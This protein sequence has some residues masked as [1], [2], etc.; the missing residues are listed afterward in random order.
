MKNLVKKL[1]IFSCSLC[2]SFLLFVPF[3]TVNADQTYIIAS[4]GIYMYNTGNSNMY[5]KIVNNTS[6]VRVVA[7]TNETPVTSNTRLKFFWVSENSFQIGYKEGSMPSSWNNAIQSAATNF[8]YYFSFRT[9][10]NYLST[11]VPIIYINDPNIQWSD[12][13]QL[14]VYAVYYTFGE[15]ASEPEPVLSF[16]NLADVS[17][18]SNIAG[19]G[20]ETINN[21]DV[22]RWNNVIDNHNNLVPDDAL[23]DIRA[24]PGE[25]QASDK[26]SLLTKIYTDLILDYTNFATLANVPFSDGTKSFRWGDVVNRFSPLYTFG[27]FTSMIQGSDYWYKQGWIYEVRLRIPSE[28][29]TS[30]WIGIRNLTSSGVVNSNNAIDNNGLDS[31]LIQTINNINT[32]NTT[33]NNEFVTNN[34]YYNSYPVPENSS[35]L[36]DLTNPLKAI[37]EAILNLPRTIGEKIKGVLE[38]LS[39]WLFVYDFDIE[40]FEEQ[41]E[42]ML[43][44][45]GAFGEILRHLEEIKDNVDSHNGQSFVPLISWS[46]IYVMDEIMIPAG[47][48]NL[49]NLVADDPM[50]TFYLLYQ[51][52]ISGY[53]YFTLFRF[54]YKKIIKTLRS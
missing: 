7:F 54:I 41:K 11:P 16:G 27:N 26:Q 24:I 12:T 4:D 25:Y 47:T 1:I 20:S 46:D 48:F 35:D 8:E 50:H 23:V 51:T 42:H 37:L 19:S 17:Y 34:Y 29:Y 39:E 53:L 52:I 30:E 36:S 32:I 6:E 33:E 13:G 49:A 43:D 28:D 31:T 44:E 2:L 5:C 38:D 40:D 45:S 15:G 3:I 14:D 21:V 18:S 9:E 10:W 22:I